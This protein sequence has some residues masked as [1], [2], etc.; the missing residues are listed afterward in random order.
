[1]PRRHRLSTQGDRDTTMDMKPRG[2]MLQKEDRRMWNGIRDSAI[3]R[4]RHRCSGSIATDLRTGTVRSC[5]RGR[6]LRGHRR[7]K[8]HL[9]LLRETEL[10]PGIE[11]AGRGAEVIGNL[12][13]VIDANETTGGEV[14]RG[15]VEDALAFKAK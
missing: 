8:D 11:L 10:A 7:S 1:M 5:T 3:L 13:P 9:R 15:G 2:V 14:M 4:C 6:L 12:R